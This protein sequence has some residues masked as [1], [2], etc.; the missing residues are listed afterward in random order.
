M[1]AR[2]WVYW[3][4]DW[5]KLTLAPGQV[6]QLYDGGSTEEGYWFLEELFEHDG[7]TVVRTTRSGGSDC[8]GP[9]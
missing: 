8:D 2:F 3:N 1:N 7:D 4:Y 9:I 5:V 6:L